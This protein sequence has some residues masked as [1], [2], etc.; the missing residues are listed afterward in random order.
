VTDA[1]GYTLFETVVAAALCSTLG[2]ISI[3][4]VGGAIDRERTT[5][6][7]RVLAA[8]LQRARFEALKRGR[9]VAVRLV[10][11]GDRTS[12]QLFADG[13]GDGVRQTDIDA[14]VDPPLSLLEYLDQH[15]R[16]IG[17]RINQAVPDV[18]GGTDL[19]AGADPIRIGNTALLAF[20]PLGSAT[21]GTLYVAGHRGPQMAIRVFGATARVRLLMFDAQARQ[22]RH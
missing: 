19:A 7:A 11:V 3:P 1:R 13:D 16:G 21:N 17:L 14:G 4:I 18:S 10:L 12:L 5:I 15:A 8:Q 9:G 2:A 22:W 20:S 6:G